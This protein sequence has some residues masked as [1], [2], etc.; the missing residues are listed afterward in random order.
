MAPGIGFQTPLPGH[1]IW[2]WS[3]CWRGRPS[4][5][6]GA[7][8]QTGLQVAPRRKPEVGAAPPQWQGGSHPEPPLAGTWPDPQG[9][10]PTAAFQ[11]SPA[12]V[13]W[14]D[15]VEKQ[16]S[17][18]AWQ[19]WGE[20]TAPTGEKTPDRRALGSAASGPGGAASRVQVP[21]EDAE[22]WCENAASGEARVTQVGVFC[23]NAATFL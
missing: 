16:T 12:N 8:V 3:T 22:T 11:A 2:S 1:Q 10:G 6:P 4:S 20:P 23:A 13:L 17:F 15:V 21:Q 18:A 5:R 19:S 14:R 7:N 9:G